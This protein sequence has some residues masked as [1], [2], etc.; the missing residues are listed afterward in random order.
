MGVPCPSQHGPG[1][2]SHRSSHYCVRVSHVVVTL[3]SEA[4]AVILRERQLSSVSYVPTWPLGFLSLGVNPQGQRV[5]VLR[6]RRDG[7]PL[8]I[9]SEGG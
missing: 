8:G 3:C 5:A 9:E 6:G 2:P 1:A 4:A 7:S